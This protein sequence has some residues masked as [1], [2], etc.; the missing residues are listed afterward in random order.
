MTKPA[1]PRKRIRNSLFWQLIVAFA[2]IICLAGGGVLVIWRIAWSKDD[3]SR[4]FPHRMDRCARR[5]ATHYDQHRSWDGA[6]EIIVAYPCGQGRRSAQDERT[7]ALL[8][9]LDGTIVAAG[10][11]VR[12]GR[13][14]SEREM[15][16]ATPIVVDDESVGLLLKYSFDRPGGPPSAV[17][18][19]EWKSPAL[20][21]GTNKQS[22]QREAST[23]R[24]HNGSSEL[25]G[26]AVI[27]P[28][29]PLLASGR[30]RATVFRRA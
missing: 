20:C 5:L 24:P 25:F 11:E 10:D 23:P 16:H 29:S 12:I 17:A 6:D 21:S 28:R 3:S 22:L 2:V 9:T 26:D 15:G 27:H 19:F 30:C 14:L 7:V 1:D 8:A 13:S 18:P 4:G